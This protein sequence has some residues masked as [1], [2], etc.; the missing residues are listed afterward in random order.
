MSKDKSF[1]TNKSGR[2]RHRGRAKSPKDIE[3]EDKAKGHPQGS[4]ESSS[5]P[6]SSNESSSPKLRG[7][8]KGF[9]KNQ[10][11]EAGDRS[12]PHGTRAEGAEH[13]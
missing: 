4:E 9:G 11:K 3:L 5:T 1:E 12:A 2:G 6:Q 8:Q 7:S 13:G 10:G